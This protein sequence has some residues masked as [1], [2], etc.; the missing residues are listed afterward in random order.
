[1]GTVVG[2][3]KGLRA[4]ELVSMA[5]MIEE[6]MT[7]NPN[8]PD[9]GPLVAQLGAARIAMMTAITDAMDG[10]RTA[11]F[12]QRVRK[13]ELKGVLTRLLNHV[14][15]VALGDLP[16]LV[17]SGFPQRRPALRIGALPAPQ[18]LV[19]RFGEHPGQV[20][21]GW[22]PVRGARMYRVEMSDAVPD[23]DMVWRVVAEVPH[24]HYTVTDL[25]SLRYYWFR[26]VA[27][28]TAGESPFS[29]PAQSLAI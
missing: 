3:M 15:S 18:K 26:V 20:H 4:V 22:A 29:D 14:V 23:Q 2:G 12:V 1:M 8:F 9:A 19:A 28:G 10:G 17:S 11:H 6:H 21:L 13:A 24:A 5:Q 16:K 25:P 7:G 27:V